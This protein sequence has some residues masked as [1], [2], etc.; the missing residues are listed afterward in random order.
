M[1]RTLLRTAPLLTLALLACETAD[2]APSAAEQHDH[3]LAPTAIVLGDDLADTFVHADGWLVSPRLAAPEGATRAALQIDLRLERSDAPLVIEARGFSDGNAAEWVPAEVTWRE[4]PYAVARAE[5]GFVADEIQVRVPDGD[6]A[7]LSALRY[8]AVVPL[9]EAEELDA[10]E[11]TLLGPGETQQPLSSVW[12]NIGVKSRAYWG[13]RATRCTTQSVSKNKIA[14]HHTVTPRTYAGTYAARVR[15]IQAFHMDGRGWCDI[16]YH[17]MVTADGTLW[18]AR[19]VHLNGAH[20][21]GYNMGNVGVSFIGCFHPTSECNNMG[22]KTPPERMVQQGARLIARIASH[23]GISRSSSTV[24]GHRDHPSQ[25]TSCP[26]DNLHA[27]LPALRSYTAPPA[28][29]CSGKNGTWCDGS[30]LV[31][32]TDGVETSRT[33]CAHGCESM[34]MGTPDRCYAPP[35]PPPP[36]SCS[37]VIRIGGASRYATAANVSKK[38]FPNGA[39]VVVIASGADGNTDAIVAGPLARH[40]GGAVLLTR[41]T[42]L[43]SATRA[44]IDRLGATRA[45]IVGGPNTVS[46]DVQTALEG[47]GLTVTRLSGVNRY[48]TSAAVAR[49]IGAAAGFAFV[50]SG[51]ERGL[52]DAVAAAAT[53]AALDAPLLLVKKGAVPAEVASALSELG[54]TRTYL[55]GGTTTVSSAVQ[56]ALPSA[57]RLFGGDRYTTAAAVAGAGRILGASPWRVFLTRGDMTTDAVTVGATGQMLLLSR[58]D[59]LPAASRSFL[60]EYASRATLVGGTSSLNDDVHR[61][62]CAAF[63]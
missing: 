21:G 22:G 57:V 62:T 42:A 31:R 56:R 41:S 2:L 36:P 63:D 33:S 59:G 23:Y 39:S 43:P 46:S 20:V 25:W 12:S 40:E 53:A 60:S 6:Q 32:C 37:D 55:T 9:D 48:D 13:A 50:A 1:S 61:Q 10:A 34:P 3:S 18:E 35:A 27:R 17:F 49:R 16:G 44:E 52:A 54:I 29:F 15:Q 14:V 51:E 8:E 30:K 45:I 5:L 58:T 47:L 28:G 11:P 4:A 38:T 26:G 7:V 19:P 24:K